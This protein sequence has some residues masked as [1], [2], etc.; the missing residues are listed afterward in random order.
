MVRQQTYLQ[1]FHDRWHSAQHDAH[2]SAWQSLCLSC[3]AWY[4]LFPAFPQSIQIAC[5]AKASC[6][7]TACRPCKHS[8]NAAYALDQQVHSIIS[9]TAPLP[10]AHKL[11]EEL[12]WRLLQAQKALLDGQ[13]HMTEM[14]TRV[15]YL[16]FSNRQPPAMSPTC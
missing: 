3:I 13:P 10:T 7:A 15:D 5:T 9:E 11:H 6:H 1:G 12:M 4:S 14:G 8:Q 2:C 16:Q